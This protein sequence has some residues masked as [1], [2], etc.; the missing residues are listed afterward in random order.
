[1]SFHDDLE[2]I[3]RVSGVADLA[4][5][6]FLARGRQ[7]FPDAAPPVEIAKWIET[8]RTEAPHLFVQPVVTDTARQERERILANLNPAERLTRGRPAPPTWEEKQQR[9]GPVSHAEAAAFKGMSVEAFM[10]LPPH[11]RRTAVIELQQQQGQ[12]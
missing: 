1:M 6:D 5:V 11:A 3:G 9:Q 2:A 4:L 7:A 12:A 8:L 10:Q